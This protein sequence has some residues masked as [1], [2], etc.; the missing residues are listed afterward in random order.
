MQVNL[1]NEPCCVK[2]RN[3]CDLWMYDL[4]FVREGVARSVYKKANP[5]E[6]ISNKHIHHV[7]FMCDGGCNGLYNLRAKTPEEHCDEH[8]EL[9][10]NL[11]VC[12][13]DWFKCEYCGCDIYKPISN[14]IK[15]CDEHYSKQWRKNNPDYNKQ[16]RENNPEK[17]KE[18]SEKKVY[19]PKPFIWVD[20]PKDYYFQM[21]LN[22]KEY[23]KNYRE[24]NKDY[25]NYYSRCYS[26]AISIYKK[27]GVDFQ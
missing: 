1:W 2:E 18:Y 25:F 17:V 13:R 6:D 19:K 11:F 12:E 27:E 14:K 20:K 16:W 21:E 7:E 9:S 10:D 23:D 15:A 8:P 22:Q 26:K 24:K 5:D 4:C 3:D